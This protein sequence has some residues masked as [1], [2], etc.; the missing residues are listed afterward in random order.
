MNASKKVGN[1][2]ELHNQF[3]ICEDTLTYVKKTLM[4]ISNLTG[5]E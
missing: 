1:A 3:D 2:S 5:T 4:Y